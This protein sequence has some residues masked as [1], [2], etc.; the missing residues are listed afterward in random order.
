[1]KTVSLLQAKSNSEL[2]VKDEKTISLEPISLFELAEIL[3]GNSETATH[4]K[5]KDK[6]NS[7]HAGGLICWC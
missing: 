3:G 5:D 1:M 7:G 2:V 6:Q 4:E